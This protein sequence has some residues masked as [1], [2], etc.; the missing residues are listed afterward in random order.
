MGSPANEPRTD[1]YPNVI[2]PIFD[3]GVSAPNIPCQT[4]IACAFITI[5]PENL[6]IDEIYGVNLDIEYTFKVK[7][8]YSK[9]DVVNYHFDTTGYKTFTANVS[10]DQVLEYANK[11]RVKLGTAIQCVTYESLKTIRKVIISLQDRDNPAFIASLHTCSLVGYDTHLSVPMPFSL[12]LDTMNSSDLGF[13]L[14]FY[15]GLDHEFSFKILSIE[16]DF[17]DGALSKITNPILVN[18]T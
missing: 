8:K 1:L 2:Y 15:A 17:P 4:F 11:R 10:K 9:G 6:T 5:N 12:T 16:H 18:D 3:Q 14:E 7:A 13:Y